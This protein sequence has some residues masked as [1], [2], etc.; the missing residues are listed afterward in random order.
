MINFENIN[1]FSRLYD[2]LN[3]YLRFTH[4]HF[5]YKKFHIYGKENIPPKGVPTFIISNHQN[6]LMDAL[7][8]LYLF[9]DRRQPVYIARGDIFKNQT[10][11]KILRFLKIMP[12]FRSRDG[13]RKDI[14][15]NNTSFGIA[16]QVLKEGGT[17]AIFPEAGHQAGHFLSS[18]KKGFPRI[19]F[20]AEE[21]A[22]FELNLQIV[23]LNIHYSDY[24]NFRSELLVTVGKPFSFKEFFELYKTE[25]NQAYIALNEKSKKEIK[26]LSLD[27]EDKEHYEDYET[28]R[29][30]FHT[31]LKELKKRDKQY[32][33]TQLNEDI[34]IVA[35]INRLKEQDPSTFATLM[36]T[37]SDYR[38]E[39][40]KLNL[41]DWLISNKKITI[42]RLILQSAVLFL[43][44]PIFLFG[45]IHNIIPFS[46]PNILK[47]K[48]KDPMLHSSLH[49]A[50]SVIIS[51]PIIYLILFF[52]VLCISEKV[53]ISLLYIG[54]V[55]G[56]LF[57]F[58]G[59][60]RA[61]IKWK[62]AWRYYLLNKKKNL[63]IIRLKK[64][65]EELFSIKKRSQ[66]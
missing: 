3:R 47:R 15:Q 51:F 63:Q 29:T 40:K 52:I 34:T 24:F 38:N 2:I 58:Y 21:F 5:Y 19:A 27:I 53:V 22:N 43:L 32:L 12:T 37:A 35:N 10:I 26:S 59:Y 8:I 11:A 48:I 30:I 64:L 13:N 56:A 9:S 39:L 42:C 60:K 20:K 55:F 6:G 7:A 14:E 23:P 66:I 61:F 44:F 31:P 25:P 33:H 57:I 17:L 41:R 4:N 49:Y 46:L 50:L 65:K 28:L 36:Q 16:A 45:F 18:F 54:T 62:A 1:H